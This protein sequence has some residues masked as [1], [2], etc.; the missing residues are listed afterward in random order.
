MRPRLRLH[1][2]RPWRHT[3]ALAG[4]QALEMMSWRR[5][6]LLQ[7]A[8]AAMSGQH[9]ASMHGFM[10]KRSSLPVS[11]RQSSCCR[12]LDLF[13]PHHREVARLAIGGLELPAGLGRRGLDGLLGW[14]GDPAEEL[15]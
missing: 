4:R 2:K 8:L 14:D 12:T 3:P 6:L 15:Q 5:R 11:A 10:R 1:L 7:K 9:G 13:H